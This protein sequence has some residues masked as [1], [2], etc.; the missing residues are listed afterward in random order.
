MQEFVRTLTKE[1]I[2]EYLKS[3]T[4]EIEKIGESVQGKMVMFC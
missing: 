2:Q 1:N 4:A 3:Y